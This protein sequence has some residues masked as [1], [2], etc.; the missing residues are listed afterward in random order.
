MV[1]SI[2]IE[3]AILNLG[4][5]T[6]NPYIYSALDGIG[7]VPL[8]IGTPSTFTGSYNVQY[9]FY[10]LP[11][12][13]TLV[14]GQTYDIGVDFNSFNNPDLDF[15]SYQFNSTNPPFTIGSI[16]VTDGEELRCGPCNTLMPHLRLTGNIV[17]PEQPS[18]S[19]VAGGLIVAAG[20][21]R[22]K[23]AT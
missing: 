5:V 18:L 20:R 8:A 9:W 10:D 7:Q 11:V 13:Y 6:L 23:L 15:W 2:G 4:T 19:F 21:L 17:V 14:S 1:T 12:S 16:I 22:R 3:L